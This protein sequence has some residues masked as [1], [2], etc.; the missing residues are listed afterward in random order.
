MRQALDYDFRQLKVKIMEEQNKKGD[1]EK[2][3]RTALSELDSF[4]ATL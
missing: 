2:K 4:E 1:L 3:L